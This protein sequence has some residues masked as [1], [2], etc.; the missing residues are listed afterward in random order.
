MTHPELTREQRAHVLSIAASIEQDPS[1]YAQRA[2]GDGQ[3]STPCCIAGRSGIL[4]R[5]PYD[6][7]NQVGFWS[8]L[9]RRGAALGLRRPQDREAPGLFR[10]VWPCAWLEPERR[11]SFRPQP[12]HAVQVLR[13]YAAGELTVAELSEEW[14]P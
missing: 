14:V 9:C 12:E 5:D 6:S 8:W 11:G 13:R 3:C 1:L 10:A 4:D 2:Y 7:R